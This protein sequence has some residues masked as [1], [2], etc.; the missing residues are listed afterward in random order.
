VL[1]GRIKDRIPG[2]QTN[3]TWVEGRQ[4]SNNEGRTEKIP[5]GVFY[6]FRKFYYEIGHGAYPAA[7]A[8][9]MS[10]A[11]PSQYLFGTDFPAEPME[12]TVNELPGLKLSPEVLQALYRGNAERLWPRFKTS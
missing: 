12:S 10:V 3:G 6:E 5:N 4:L 11:P 9:M 7:M 8:A 2:F 1:A